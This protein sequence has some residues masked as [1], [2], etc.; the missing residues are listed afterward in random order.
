MEGEENLP[1]TE[2]LQEEAEWLEIDQNNLGYQIFNDDKIV[3]TVHE[4]EPPIDDDDDNTE[5]IRDEKCSGP[6]H[7]K[8]FNALEIFILVDVGCGPGNV[9]YKKLL[10]LLPASLK[11]IIGVDLSFENLEYARIHHQKDPRISYEQL[12]ILT[13]ALPTEYL[14]AFDLIISL[15]CFHFVGDH[16]KALKN[17]YKMLKP[18]GKVLI[19]Y[20]GKSVLPSMYQHVYDNPKW[21]Q[22]MSNF[23]NAIYTSKSEKAS[24]QLLEEVG[25]KQIQY[26]EHINKFLQP[27]DSSIFKSQNMFNVPRHLENEFIENHLEYLEKNGYVEFDDDGRKQYTFPFTVFIMNARKF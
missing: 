24:E 3:K 7:A 17:I 23:K 8:A 10:P 9:T 27:E 13:D 25:F 21:S 22:Y 14:E 19:S 26:K 4:I 2:E 6:S 18:G 1:E 11:K 16:R 20:L 12:D 15:S 5:N